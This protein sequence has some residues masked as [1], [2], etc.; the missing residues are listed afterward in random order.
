MKYSR[1]KYE[2]RTTTLNANRIMFNS[3]TV[4]QKIPSQNELIYMSDDELYYIAEA[5]VDM[6]SRLLQR[7]IVNTIH[8]NCDQET[9]L[10][11][12]HLFTKKEMEN[13]MLNC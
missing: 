3:M 8:F 1:K 4:S 6:P 10:R 9:I 13:M 5:I 7:S 11:F 2:K 12:H